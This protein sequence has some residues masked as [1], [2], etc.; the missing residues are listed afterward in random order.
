VRPMEATA[1]HHHDTLFPR[2]AKERQHLVDIVATPRSLTMGNDLKEAF[3]RPIVDGPKDAPQHTTGHAAPTPIAPPALALEGLRAFALA[4]AQWASRP[5]LPLS[6][7]PPAGPGEGKA[8]QDCFLSIEQDHLAPTGT[9]C[10]R[11]EVERGVG[12]VGRGRCQLPRWPAGAAR[13]FFQTTRPLARPS[14]PPVCCANTVASSRQ[15]HGEE[16]AP[17]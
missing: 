16:R 13:I 2:A 1:I 3:R 14:W 7:P 12:Q 10:E 4:P 6:F 17:C 11:C 15:L 5:A 8:P 9:V